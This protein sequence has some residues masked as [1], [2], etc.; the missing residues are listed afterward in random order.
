MADLRCDIAGVKSPNPFWLAS[1]PPTDKEYNVARAF[2]AGCRREIGLRIALGAQ[3]SDIVRL[4]LREN[5]WV[6]LAGIAIGLAGA[7]GV[8][9]VIESL[10]FGVAA[11]DPLA[12]GIAAVLLALVAL[13]ASLWPAPSAPRSPIPTRW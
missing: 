4:M 12:L 8:G 9:R 13:A 10:L 3:R 11:T 5:L 7:I 2:K 1:A 6:I